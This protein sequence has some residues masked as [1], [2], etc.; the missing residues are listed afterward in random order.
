V[1]VWQSLWRSRIVRY[2]Q[3]AR[4]RRDHKLQ[5]VVAHKKLKHMPTVRTAGVAQTQ[6]QNFLPDRPA[7]ETDETIASQIRLMKDE[8]RKRGRD[9]DAIG[10]MMNQTFADRRHLIVKVKENYPCLFDENEVQFL[11]VVLTRVSSRN[12]ELVIT[13]NYGS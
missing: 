8:H 7:G 4:A 13:G 2:F 10:E 6:L 3:N 12:Y 9:Q 11:A 1:Y 5:V